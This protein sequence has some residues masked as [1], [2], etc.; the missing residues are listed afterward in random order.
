MSNA[1]SL[2]PSNGSGGGSPPSSNTSTQELDNLLRRELRVSDPGDARAVA[3]ALLERYKNDPRARAIQTEAQ[4]LPFST[5]P[6][7][8][9]TPSAMPSSSDGEW[10]QAV[11]DVERSLEELTTNS[12]L[13]S[14]LPEL[15]GW[16]HAIRNLI[17]EGS[18]AARAALDVNQRDKAFG[19]RRSLGDYARMARLVGAATPVVNMNYRKLAQGLDEVEIGRAHV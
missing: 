19:I 15:R 16:A 11:D 5:A 4:G 18:N 7:V 3:A 13:T 9:A 6:L 14:V 8:M 2:I 1:N 10:G 17:T 12:L